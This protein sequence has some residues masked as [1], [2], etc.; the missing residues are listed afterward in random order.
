MEWVLV[1]GG[2]REGMEGGVFFWGENKFKLFCFLNEK[3]PI[4]CEIA[5][6]D[7]LSAHADKSELLRWVGSIQKKPSLIIV[8]HGSVE[9][10]KN[11]AQEICATFHI[12]VIA[13]C[14]QAEFSLFRE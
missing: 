13:A 9:A 11:L 7:Q 5:T 8:N 6:L 3:F 1:C 12:D 4:E 2:R 10:Q 14:E